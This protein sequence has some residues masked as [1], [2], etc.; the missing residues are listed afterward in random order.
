MQALMLI[1]HCVKNS[2]TQRNKLHR[3][4]TQAFSVAAKK[5]RNATQCKCLYSAPRANRNEFYF[6]RSPQ[7]KDDS[8][9][10][11]PTAMA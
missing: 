8:Q 11:Q 6:L 10:Q 5:L 1:K 2:T 4:T 3:N 7:R 9:S